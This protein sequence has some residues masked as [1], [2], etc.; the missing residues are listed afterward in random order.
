M[1][2]SPQPLPPFPS[3]LYQSFVDQS[4]PA[5]QPGLSAS[6]VAN[7]P[8]KRIKVSQV[9]EDELRRCAS[10]DIS[11]AFA[12]LA[13]LE[14]LLQTLSELERQG[15]PGRFLT[16]DYQTFTEPA[17]LRKLSSLKNIEVRMY[18][19]APGAGFHTKGYIFEQG[20]E[21]H[22]LI[23]SSNFTRSAFVLN[24]EWNTRLVVKR[25]GGFAAEVREEF[26]RLWES[27]RTR[28]LAEVIAEYE[29]QYQGHC[30]A[31]AEIRRIEL[32]SSRRPLEPN[33]MQREF[34]KNLLAIR[35]KKKTRALL[36]SAT[37]TGKTYAAAFGAK[38]LKPARLLFIVHREQIARQAM[39][40][41]KRVLGGPESDYGILSGGRACG[42]RHVFATV[43]TASKDAV[44]AQLGA[45]SFD[46]VIIDEAHRAGAA[47][48]QKILDFFQPKFCLGMTASPERTDG[49]DI[50]ELF[51]HNIAYEIRLQTALE[52]NLLCPFHYF[53]LTEL[54]TGG[55][56]GEAADFSRLA[57]D[58]RVQHVLSRAD[59]FGH[60][61]KRL[62]G[63]VF[64]SSLEECQAL[65]Q[66]FN[67][68]ER[69]LRTLALSGADSQ[70]KRED[71][72]RRLSQDEGE[73]CL[74]YI[75]TVD[76]FNEGVDIPEVNQVILLRPTQSAIVFIQQ[77]GRGLR[78][79]PGKDFVVVLDF[80]GSYKNNYLIPIALSGDYSYSKDSMRRLVSTGSAAIAG[81]SSIHFDPIARER[82][83]KAIDNANTHSIQ[84]LKS[85]YTQLKLKL[86]RIPSLNDYEPHGTIDA[87]KFFSIGRKP[88]S[89]YDFLKKHEPKLSE[90]LSP[91]A[92][93]MLRYLSSRIGSAKRVSEALALAPGGGE[94]NLWDRLRESLQETYGIRPADRHLENVFLVLGNR[95]GK[96]AA[97]MQAWASCELVRQEGPRDFRA[98][99]GLLRELAASAA[100]RQRLQELIRF[101]KHRY[102]SRFSRRYR[103]TSLVLD[104]QYSYE[105]VC[106]LL[107]WQR[108]LNAQ[109]MGGY[110]YDKDSATLPV[111]IN[112]EKAKDAIAYQDRF[113][114][115][116]ELIAL[117][118]KSRRTDSAD[119]THIY[120]RA[121]ADRDNRIYLFVRRNKDGDEAKSFYFLGEVEAQGDPLPVKLSGEDAFEI[122]YRLE[123]PVR[124][125]IYRYITG[126]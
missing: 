58:E 61:G 3:S 49:F 63:L 13:G 25:E 66:K 68:S 21:C 88:S 81:P 105:D 62:K 94:A 122:R 51:H 12:R 15:V 1:P 124:D 20:E 103:D 11:V 76:I 27:P 74:D 86:G 52:Q 34:V 92:A 39:E 59:F 47:S 117:S 38:S 125:D 107:D 97:E 70:E 93:L 37:G 87:V 114:S 85:A 91:V 118:K 72:I 42:A 102:E 60:S 22:I 80:I 100:F 45:R 67:A 30:A 24:R 10:F 78:K 116:S 79:A 99:A 71:A 40:S 50:F 95:F 44:M 110:F 96:T 77:L 18:C 120:K 112:Y 75:F 55:A 126:A 35:D 46:L 7:I 83:F 123:S 113:V 57:S 5:S 84:L 119:A 54:I 65:S 115:E 8:E 28:P 17:A 32:A 108:N 41:F 69:C 29:A 48:Y 16:T 109:N 64:C 90:T 56:P 89:Y 43:Q 2:A 82:I 23:G 9:I 106:R 33:R 104:E 121:E 31:L 36:V 73:D 101:V 19:C 4:F 98:S 6:L 53:G 14:P 26:T 111:F